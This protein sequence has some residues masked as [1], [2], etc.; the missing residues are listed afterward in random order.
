LIQA[1]P[2]E[3]D[4]VGERQAPT[5]NGCQNRSH[6]MNDD[7][8][9]LPHA[10][11]DD[12]IAFVMEHTNAERSQVEA[13]LAIE[14]EFMVAVG[15]MWSLTDEPWPFRYYDEARRAEI[16]AGPHVVDDEVLA[17]D[18]DQLAGV[19]HVLAAEI[20]IAATEFVQSR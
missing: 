15:I 5:V 12:Q 17:R 2:G 18:A 7:P 1:I 6:A 4:D 19:P 20:Y 11:P 8:R 14:N 10:D 13:C 9:G 3:L 16:A